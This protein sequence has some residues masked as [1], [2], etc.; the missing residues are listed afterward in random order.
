M[1]PSAMTL[2]LLSSFAIFA[3]S[4]QRR[5]ALLRTGTTEPRFSITPFPQLV[6]RLRQ[7]LIYGFGQRKMPYYRTAG[8]AH[9]FIFSGFLVLLLR[10][11]LLWGQGY[12]AGFDLWGILAKGTWLGDG[13]N[14]LKDV[15]AVLVILG[16]G[17]F[18]YYRTIAPQKR[19]SLSA[20]GLIILFIIIT[21]MVADIVYDATRLLLEASKHEHPVQLYVLEPAGSIV[22]LGLDQFHFSDT[23][24]RVLHHVGFWWHASFVLFFLNLLPYSKHFH[25]ITAIPNVFAASDLPRG[26]LP[27]IEDLEGR[28]EREE[29]LGFRTITDLSWKDMLDLYT[30]TECGRCS[31]HCPAYLT[32]KKL[33]PK[34]LTIALRDHLYDSESH[35]IKDDTASLETLG[36]SCQTQASSNPIEG[37]PPSEAYFR[38]SKPLDLVPGIIH[39]DVIWACTTCRACEQ[40]CPVNISYVDKIIK[41]RREKVMLDAAF[42]SELQKP[43]N[44]IETQAN[45]WNLAANDRPAWAQGLEVPLMSEHPNATVLYWVGCAASYDER[46]KRIARATVKLF[47]HANVDFAILGQKERCTGDPARRAGNEYL[48]QIQAETNVETLKECNAERKTIVTTCPHCFNTLHNE[49]P[50]FDGHFKVVHHTDFLLDLMM[51]RKLIPTKPVSAVVAFHDS[52]YLGR[53]NDIY[54]SPR[55][56][57]TSIPGVE[58][59]EVPHW[60]RERGLCCGAGGA[61]MFMEEQNDNRVNNKRTLQ[62]LDTGATTIATAC[63]FCVTMIQDGLKAVDK[64][65]TVQNMDVAEVLERSVL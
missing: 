44:G 28:V 50:Q 60:N 11:V 53:Y 55:Q 6:A 26:M 7:T 16:A 58:L 1:N 20:E 34:H 27:K 33:S 23:T 38:A 42:P 61:Q 4:F 2:L 36:L 49:Y 39:P 24:L 43:F 5:W 19:M 35:L 18:V 65:E 54:E 32:D 59:R 37:N 3:W 12:D 62:L 41:L 21:M 40:E 29:P 22:A 8:I 45:P 25:V 17:V 31:D 51:E 48:F 30:C 15:F 14:V 64:E 63:P 57:L 56:I 47:K 13:Y 46:A 52:C 9:L 10:S